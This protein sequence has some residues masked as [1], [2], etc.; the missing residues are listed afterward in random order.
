MALE[1]LLPFCSLGHPEDNMYAVEAE[2]WNAVVRISATLD[3]DRASLVPVV[4]SDLGLQPIEVFR[5]RTTVLFREQ[6][7]VLVSVNLQA[8][9]FQG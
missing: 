7:C 3:V 2:H 4:L 6:I 5:V 1:S 9:S 8:L